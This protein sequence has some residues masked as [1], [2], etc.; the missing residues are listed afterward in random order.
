M[1]RNF[2]RS[3]AEQVVQVVDAVYVGRNVLP[4]FVER[5]CDFSAEQAKNALLL[6]CDLGL[7]RQD[8][9]QFKSSSILCSFFSTAVDVQK[10]AALRV[11]LHE[12]EPFIVFSR[13]LQAT[14]SAETAALQTKASL[15]LDAHREEIKDT[16]ISLGT[17]TGAIETQSGGRYAISAVPASDSL[18]ELAT[19]CRTQAAAEA[20]VRKHIG[21]EDILLDR[22]DVILPLARALTKAK[23]GQAQDAVADAAI[24]FESFIARLAT[25]LGV[26]LAGASGISQK[27]DKFRV[28]SHLPKKITEAGKYISQLRNAADH[29]M[30]VDPD[31]NSVWTISEPSGRQFV[32]VTCTMI[33]VCLA[34]VRRGEFTL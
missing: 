33:S 12:Y 28:G 6:A 4:E 10:A 20:A 23:N 8:S 2:S 1:P 24:A 13:R 29:G 25:E 21:I 30:D 3:T 31:V 14:E 22:A 34:H 27:L 5:F 18:A 11:A 15:D 16:L 19:S 7:L 26:S 17:Y 9:G 32:F